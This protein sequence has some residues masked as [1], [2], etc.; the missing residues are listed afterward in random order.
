MFVWRWELVGLI[1]AVMLVIETRRQR[2]SITSQPR[3]KPEEQVLMFG[4]VAA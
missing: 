4:E 1:S 2:R 3:F